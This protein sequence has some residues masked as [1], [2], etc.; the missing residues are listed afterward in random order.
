MSQAA[1]QPTA[2]TAAEAILGRRCIRAFL[3]TPVPMP[4]IERILEMAA[5]AP[6]GTNTQPWQAIVLTG[7]AVTALTRE[8][9]AMGMANA[10]GKD[11]YQYYPVE[12]R[13][14]YLSRRRKIGWDLYR[15]VGVERGDKEGMT[16]QHARNFLFFD[17]PVG[18][19]FTIDAVMELGSWLDYGMFLQNFMLAARSFGLETCPQQA[20]VKYHEVIAQRLE[21]P[22][23]RTLICGMALGYADYSAPENNFVTER[24]PLSEFVRFVDRVVT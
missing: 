4:I 19:F 11:S 7:E 13:E 24:A 1:S 10:P 8:L 12:W 15:T 9:H 23:D 18:L 3:P 20:F 16:R 5:R 14:P 17:A 2:M 21:I 6:S 22:A